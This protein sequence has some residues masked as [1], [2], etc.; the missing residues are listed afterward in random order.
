M[1][2]LRKK[3]QALMVRG[4]DDCIA[5]QLSMGSNHAPAV[6]WVMVIAYNK[7]AKLFFHYRHNMVE[8]D[9][10]CIVLKGRNDAPLLLFSCWDPKG[11]KLLWQ[12]G[13]TTALF[14]SLIVQ[15]C[16]PLLLSS[17]LAL[18]D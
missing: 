17:C 7:R 18:P 3:F 12:S 8:R 6:V 5:L 15:N 9:D 10:H 11:F 16:V 13:M 2:T 4:D 14:C 1:I